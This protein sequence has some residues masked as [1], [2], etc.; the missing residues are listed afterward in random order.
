M[1]TRFGQGPSESLLERRTLRSGTHLTDSDE[2]FLEVSD[3]LRS[4]CATGESII[5]KDNQQGI[6][7]EPGIKKEPDIKKEPGIKKEPKVKEEMEENSIESGD[8]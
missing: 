6:K 3:I 8:F 4:A 2:D 1:G 7:Q 5:N